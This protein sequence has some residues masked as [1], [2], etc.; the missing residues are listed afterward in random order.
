LNEDNI[1]GRIVISKAGRD[2]GKSFIIIEIIS[3]DYVLVSDGKLRTFE[4]PKKKKIKHLIFTE[5][6]EE[7]ISNLLLS[8]KKISNSILKESLKVHRYI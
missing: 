4:T 7:E 6:F 2:K 5:Y 3:S 1:L 8:N